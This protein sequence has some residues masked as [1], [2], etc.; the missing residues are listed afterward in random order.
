MIA[1][2][3]NQKRLHQQIQHTTQHQPPSSLHVSSERTRDRVTQRIVSVFDDLT[4]IDPDWH[5]IRRLIRV[6][7]VGTRNG[8][9]YHHLA[10]YISSLA[11]SAYT[12]ADGIRGHWRIENGLHWVKDVVLREDACSL[13]KGFAPV[14]LS[15]IRTI[16]I[17]LFRRHGYSSIAKALRAVAHDLDQLFLLLQ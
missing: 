16:V 1:V 6:E 15:L 7:R 9:P 3:A 4:G 14:N 8:K 12:F 13:D 17:N 11:A 2:K 10:F 5:G